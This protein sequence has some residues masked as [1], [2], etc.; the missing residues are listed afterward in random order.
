MQLIR[1]R[2]MEKY[3]TSRTSQKKGLRKIFGLSFTDQLLWLV[4][5]TETS[6][7]WPRSHSCYVAQIK[8]VRSP[9]GSFFFYYKIHSVRTL[10]ILSVPFSL[11]EK[12]LPREFSKAVNS[13]GFFTTY[14]VKFY[15]FYYFL[16]IL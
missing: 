4:K 10:L 6:L 9:S 7:I 5:S 1:S 2:S 16:N 13:C 11:N 14:Y 3:K 12:K 15:R 8:I